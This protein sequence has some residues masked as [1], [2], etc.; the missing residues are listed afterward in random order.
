MPQAHHASNSDS[1]SREAPPTLWRW[2]RPLL[3]APPT[4]RLG[5][6]GHQPFN[7]HDL[8][9]EATLPDALPIKGWATSRGW[10]HLDAGLGVT[11]PS[12]LTISCRR[13]SVAPLGGLH[14]CGETSGAIKLGLDD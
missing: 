5:R 3:D 13:H 10:T 2:H 11:R 4:Q 14:V 1:D 7:D 6:R 8:Y 9:G 12:G